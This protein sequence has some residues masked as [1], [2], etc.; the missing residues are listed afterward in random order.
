LKSLKD[1]IGY[2]FS[3]VKLYKYLKDMELIKEKEVV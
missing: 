1:R 2:Q 3:P